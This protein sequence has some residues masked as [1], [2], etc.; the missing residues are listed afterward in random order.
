MGRPVKR[1]KVNSEYI[2]QIIKESRYNQH[3]LSRILYKSEKS[4]SSELASGVMSPD[5]VKK[6]CALVDGDWHKALMT[7]EYKQ[8][9]LEDFE[10]HEDDR[11]DQIIEHQKQIN[12]LLMD[13]IKEKRNGR[14]N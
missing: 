13:I 14:N 4:L 3:Q 11:L 12:N 6:I 1:E 10:K 9:E 5:I 7:K 2:K 8:M